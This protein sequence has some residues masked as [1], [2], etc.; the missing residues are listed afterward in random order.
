MNVML[1]L[2]CCHSG[3]FTLGCKLHNNKSDNALLGC[4]ESDIIR[5]W[6]YSWWYAV[7][8]VRKQGIEAM[9]CYELGSSAAEYEWLYFDVFEREIF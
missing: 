4:V 2:V 3:L 1:L 7:C 5:Y 6:F 8:Y 9:L